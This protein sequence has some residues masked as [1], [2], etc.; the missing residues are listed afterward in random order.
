M[1]DTLLK[2]FEAFRKEQYEDGK[3]TMPRLVAEGQSPDYFIIS[4]IDSRSNPGTIFRPAPGA[5]FAHK[6]MG[7]IVRPY[8]QGT[9]LAA[10]LQFA[11]MH[12]KVKEIIVLGHT[13]C[14]AIKAMVEKIDDEEISSFVNVAQ[15]GLEKAKERCGDHCTHGELLRHSEE[16]IVLLSTENLKAYPSVATALSEGRVTIKPWLFDMECGELLEYDETQKGFVCLTRQDVHAKAQRSA[17]D[18]K[19]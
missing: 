3:G 17:E 16:E 9:A 12:N 13:G 10:A 7:A 2:G 1:T 18:A 8:K 6:A 5:F 4:C 11:L 15:T 14:G 19:S